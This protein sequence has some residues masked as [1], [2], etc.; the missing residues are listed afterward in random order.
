LWKDNNT[1]D[2]PLAFQYVS[3]Y[4]PLLKTIAKDS[5]LYRK[6][7]LHLAAQYAVL[8]TLLGRACVGLAEVTLYAKEALALSQETRDISLQLSAYIKLA[9]AYVDEKK[10]AFAFKTMQEGEDTL[11]RN[12]K[13]QNLELSSGII[14]AFYSA[15]AMTQVKNGKNSEH[16]LAVAT[17]STTGSDPSTFVVFAPST[18]LKE[19][20][21]ICCS[22]G[23]Q[24]QAMKWLAKRMD[25]ETLA[26]RI[27][28]NERGRIET[29]NIL[30]LSMLKS[31]ERDMEKII[32]HWSA[33]I[34]GAKALRHEHAFNQAVA[35]F[36]GMELIWPGEKRIT[37]L[38]DLI[39]H[40]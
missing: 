2:I 23:D 19:A 4:L 7:A 17:D 34:E 32:H 33:G 37:E 31:K 22:K 39:V 3:K 29:I 28:Q 26:P 12:Q 13:T 15:M 27:T 20:A 1:G 18:Q 25:P 35:N 36:E 30:T 38:R 21:L 24:E 11:K 8:H 5:A 16:A 6:E 10:Y 40:W 9:W 14:G